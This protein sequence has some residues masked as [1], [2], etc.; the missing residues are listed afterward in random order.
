MAFISVD[1]K[2]RLVEAYASGRT[3][4]YEETAEMFG[5]GRA[6]VDRALR[7]KRETGD[8]CRWVATTLAASTST[9]FVLMPTHTRMPA[10]STALALG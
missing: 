3:R 10:L 1:L 7:R 2:R 6:T 9:G 8:L 4:T 5:V